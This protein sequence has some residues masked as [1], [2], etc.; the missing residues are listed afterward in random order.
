MSLENRDPVYGAWAGDSDAG[1]IYGHSF[2]RTWEW[3][4][5]EKNKKGGGG[6]VV[7]GESRLRLELS[8]KSCHF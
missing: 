5:P 2:C 7:F 8:I 3:S 1:R 6:T 4:E